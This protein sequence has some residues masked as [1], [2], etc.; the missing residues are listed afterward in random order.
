MTRQYQTDDIKELATALAKAQ[1]E[2]T[3]AIK[4]VE[5]T[6]F[7]SQYADMAAVID[8][9]KPHLAK[10]GL[11]VMQIVDSDESGKVQ[12]ITQLSHS[13]GQWVRS[14]YPVNPVKGDPQGLGSAVTY[15]RRYAY[16]CMTGVAASADDDDGNGAS[17]HGDSKPAK[18]APEVLFMSQDLRDKYV[19]HCAEQIDKATNLVEVRDQKTLNLARWNAM[20]ASGDK[21]DK[22]AYKQIAAAY[23]AGL[24]KYKEPEKPTGPQTVE[25]AKLT[26]KLD[27]VLGNDQIPD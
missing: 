5:N 13:S 6:F 25:S 11:S 17:G 19:A 23:N 2:I 21:A 18:E 4:D 24:M 10:N 8:A 7:K 1:C 12:L 3:H 15:A 9:A 26:Q 16:C 20:N 14:W 27:N 22:D